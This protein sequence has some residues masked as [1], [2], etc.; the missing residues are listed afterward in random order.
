LTARATEG[1]RRRGS[2][3]T[4][5]PRNLVLILFALLIIG[6]LSVVFFATLKTTQELYGSPLS[7]PSNPSLENY[8]RL[9]DSESMVVYFLNSIVATML[10]RK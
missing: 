10:L 7:L 1:P 2:F 8:G 6:P 9:F 5:L 4:E 3:L